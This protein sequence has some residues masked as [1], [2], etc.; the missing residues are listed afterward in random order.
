MARKFSISNEAS[1]SLSDPLPEGDESGEGVGS[2]NLERAR[3][4][5]PI[6]T[7]CGIGRQ[8]RRKNRETEKRAVMNEKLFVDC[9]CTTTRVYTDSDTESEINGML[10][11][12]PVPEPHSLV[13]ACL[14]FPRSSLLIYRFISVTH[15]YDSH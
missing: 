7:V 14:N 3:A 4:F 1:R 10:A 8:T 9:R 13:H 2:R 12:V 15:S 5:G 6:S 11:R